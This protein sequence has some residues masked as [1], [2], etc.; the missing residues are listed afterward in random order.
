MIGFSF[1]NAGATMALYGGKKAVVT[2]RKKRR[3]TAIVP[4]LDPGRAKVVAKSH[5]RR[6]RGPH[7]AGP[8]P[9]QIMRLAAARR[10]VEQDLAV[11]QRPLGAAH[12]VVVGAVG[13]HHHRMSMRGMGRSLP[14]ISSH[15][16]KA[17]QIS[18]TT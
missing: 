12:R 7:H 8:H 15:N 17:A 2:E 4:A 13:A 14:R 11:F 5:H 9:H 3:V 1:T 18:P 16:S 10:G 6:L